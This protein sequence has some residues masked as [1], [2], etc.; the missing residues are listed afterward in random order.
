MEVE[1]LFP[2]YKGKSEF[3]VGAKLVPVAGPSR[4]IS[5]RQYAAAG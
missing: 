4:I 1:A 3:R 5:G 2:R